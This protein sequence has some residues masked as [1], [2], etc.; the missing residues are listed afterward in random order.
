MAIRA[1]GWLPDSSS[2]LDGRYYNIM[3][4]VTIKIWVHD[5]LD[6]VEFLIIWRK[7]I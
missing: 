6:G 3:I 2:R 5:I 4:L 1:M 7:L